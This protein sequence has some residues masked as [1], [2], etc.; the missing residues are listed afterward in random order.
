MTFLASIPLLFW[1][2]QCSEHKQASQKIKQEKSSCDN[3]CELCD[4]FTIPIGMVFF[5][6]LGVAVY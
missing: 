3:L 6:C 5:G 4:V 2:Y 1:N